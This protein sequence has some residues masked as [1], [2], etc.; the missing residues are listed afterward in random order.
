MALYRAKNSYAQNASNHR[1]L[2]IGLTLM[3]SGVAAFVSRH[4]HNGMLPDPIALGQVFGQMGP[5]SIA[6]VGEHAIERVGS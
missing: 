5:L 4:D 3:E 2:F 6:T 1:G